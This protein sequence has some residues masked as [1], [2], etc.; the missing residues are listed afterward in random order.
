MNRLLL[1]ILAISSYTSSIAQTNIY[2]RDSHEYIPFRS[3]NL[4]G[5]KS[6]DD[7]IIQIQ[8]EDADLFSANGLARVKKNGK[9]GFIN[10]KGKI[11]IPCVWSYA[12][13]FYYGYTN[14]PK[15]YVCVYN[16]RGSGYINM[17][18]QKLNYKPEPDEEYVNSWPRIS[19]KPNFIY[20]LDSAS[21]KF[22]K[23][24]I[25][26]NIDIAHQR[27]YDPYSKEIIVKKEQRFGVIDLSGNTI[28]PYIYDTIY[29]DNSLSKILHMK[30]NGYFVK[31]DSLLGYIDIEN[32]III[33]VKYGSI[34]RIDLNIVE[35]TT[36]SGKK[37]F[38]DF[39]K[40][41]EYFDD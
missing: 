32:R 31:Q 27:D 20:V 19:K 8:F 9:Y 28:L 41:K 38:F 25:N 7:I 40:D 3:C 2:Y 26:Y 33:P 21:N 18:G 11:V 23:K 30:L 37:G 13:V 16:E 24:E 1:F 10:K 15:D 17:K 34:T 22:I 4:W 35:I 5:Y 6:N 29:K 36:K 39:E 12:D 14:C